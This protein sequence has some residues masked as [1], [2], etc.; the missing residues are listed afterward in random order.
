MNCLSDPI[1]TI[2]I[3]D[4]TQT[5]NAISLKRRNQREKDKLERIKISTE[6]LSHEMRTPLSNIIMMMDLLLVMLN[7][8]HLTNQPLDFTRMKQFYN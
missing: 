7:N 5:V 1:T 4:V 6:T 8:Q 2:Y 3:R